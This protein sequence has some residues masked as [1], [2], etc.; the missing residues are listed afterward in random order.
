MGSIRAYAQ[1][2]IGA[3]L[4]SAPALAAAPHVH[5]QGQMDVAVD[6]TRLIIEL[7]IPAHDL[8]G[9]EHPPRN[10]AEKAALGRALEAL[11]NPGGMFTMPRGAGCGEPAHRIDAPAGFSQ[12]S[13]LGA[14]DPNSAVHPD[15]VASYRWECRDAGRIDR[16]EVRVLELLRARF[17]IEARFVTREAQGTLAIRSPR[18]VVELR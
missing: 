17:E 18:A 13:A 9:F 1:A 5:G 11:A 12:T 16:L 2:V 4:A 10:A 15:F 3:A 6:A 14:T 8:V 7:R